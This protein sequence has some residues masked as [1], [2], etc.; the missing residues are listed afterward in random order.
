V[1]TSSGTENRS[2]CAPKPINTLQRPVLLP[3]IV[4]STEEKRYFEWFR[5]R[6]VKKVQGIFALRFWD[7][8]VFQASCDEPA[9]L[10]AILA[11]SS[12]HRTTPMDRNNLVT[13]MSDSRPDNREIFTL[14]HYIKAISHLDPH[15]STKNRASLRVALIT[16][17]LFI[18]LDLIRGHFQTAQ[19]HLQ[20]GLKLLGDFRSDSM[21][22]NFYLVASL[23]GESADDWILAALFRLHVQ[24]GLFNEGYGKLNTIFNSL[25]PQ[26]IPPTF[27]AILEARLHLDQL[28]HQIIRLTEL[29]RQQNE[30]VDSLSQLELLDRQKNILTDLS[31]WFSAYITSKVEL[32]EEN[33]VRDQF[34]YWI[35]HMNYS[36][37]KIMAH[38]CIWPTHEWVFDSH[39]DSFISLLSSAIALRSA[40]ASATET[41]LGDV[42]DMSKS[43]ADVGWIPPLFYTAVKCRVHRLRLHA[44]KLLE[45]TPHKEC[46]WDGKI[47]S[48]VA[49][50][51]MKIEERGFYRNY[52]AADDFHI[53]RYPD[54]RDIVLPTLPNPYR[55]HEVRVVLPDNP[56]G[57]TVL[58]CRRK[59][60]DGRWTVLVNE[61]DTLSQRWI[62]TD[63]V[64]AK[65]T[66]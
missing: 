58:V 14:Q 22:V 66:A 11:L 57:N 35:L 33:P 64:D 15:F 63:E 43:M 36:M 18:S 17:V 4:A 65:V 49:Q 42:S 12:V 56:L 23:S 55:M 48:S 52:S 34:A 39:T 5:C 59:Q 62:K 51:V 44:I 25:R 38:S 2:T 29:S 37:V 6:S 1:W 10:H 28:T 50:Q 31:D 20:N 16:C 27:H 54:G 61:F 21:N 41:L 26:L 47:L 53:N 9:V 30:P 3:I 7:T 46:I 40:S 8:L 60:D 32:L 13:A 45:T 24:V 19:V